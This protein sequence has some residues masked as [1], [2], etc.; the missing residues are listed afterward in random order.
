MGFI[1][2]FCQFFSQQPQKRLQGEENLTERDLEETKRYVRDVGDMEM[3]E[4]DLEETAEGE[5]E[6]RDV[7]RSAAE[8][9]STNNLK[10][11]GYRKL[12]KNAAGKMA[13]GLR[14]MKSFLKRDLENDASDFKKS[15]RTFWSGHYE[16]KNRKAGKKT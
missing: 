16:T 8:E 1:I 9:D 12:L 4:R 14:I 2:S 15:K 13:T 6:E 10:K 11:R 3:Q 5:K 7:E